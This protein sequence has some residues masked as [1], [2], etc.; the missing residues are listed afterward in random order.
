MLWL[1]CPQ[2][3]MWTICLLALGMRRMLAELNTFQH[4]LSPCQRPKTEKKAWRRNVCEKTARCATVSRGEGNSFSEY[5]ATRCLRPASRTRDEIL[6]PQHRHYNLWQRSHIVRPELFLYSTIETTFF[7]FPPLKMNLMVCASNQ[8]I[9]RLEL[10]PLWYHLILSRRKKTLEPRRR[11]INFQC[12]STRFHGQ[13]S[14]N[15]RWSINS[16]LIRESEK[17]FNWLLG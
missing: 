4:S 14:A 15:H 17:L 5:G 9:R 1:Q 2:N 12:S 8:L 3:T 11:L 7:F 16:P 10:S 6:A 13:L